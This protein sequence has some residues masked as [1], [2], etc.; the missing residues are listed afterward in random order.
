[1]RYEKIIKILSE[2]PKDEIAKDDLLDL[3]LREYKNENNKTFINL[4][5]ML[6]GYG[7]IA[8]KTK[9]VY[10]ILDKKSYRMKVDDDLRDINDLISSKY[11]DIKHITWTT[12]I[13]NDFSQHYAITNHIIVETEKIAISRVI[14]LLKDN[15]SNDY[16]V[17]SEEM[18]V[19]NS[20]YF[21][22]D[23]NILVIVKQL[24]QKAPLNKNDGMYVPSL[25]KIMVD[26][27]KDRMYLQY[28]GSELNYIFENI[29][30][31]YSINL[32][33]LLSYAKL[34][35]VSEDIENTLEKTKILESR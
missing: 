2:Y 8:D 10:Q 17:I 29:V 25:E 28:Q 20:E 12:G 5:A 9:C 33:K 4:V 23:N 26:L 15:L 3:Y 32:R 13:I 35:G 21:L 16:T 1:M 34:R 6:K 11:P 24:I 22:N 14:N 7:I 30:D 19:K 31:D 18:F 27:M